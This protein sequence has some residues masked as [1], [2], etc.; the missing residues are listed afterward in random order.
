MVLFKL[1][2]RLS[3]EPLARVPHGSDTSVLH[4][5]E[6]MTISS[7]CWFCGNGGPAGG[8][9]NGNDDD[10]DND[11]AFV[12][13]SPDEIVDV[14]IGR[15]LQPVLRLGIVNL[16]KTMF[17]LFGQGTIVAGVESSALLLRRRRFRYSSIF[18]RF[19]CVASLVSVVSTTAVLVI[20]RE[21]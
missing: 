3:S 20:S 11:V 4:P 16:D 5:I 7:R 17:L 10:D 14:V 1:L 2:S 8:R 9:V 13:F 6:T 12:V 15:T 18:K 19:F 21:L